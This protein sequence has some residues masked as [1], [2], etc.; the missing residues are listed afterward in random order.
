MYQ[1]A[2]ALNGGRTFLFHGSD[3][4]HDRNIHDTLVLRSTEQSAL[5]TTVLSLWKSTQRAC[6]SSGDAVSN[7][8]L[9]L[10][11]LL[12][13]GSVHRKCGLCGFLGVWLDQVSCVSS[14]E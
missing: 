11:S 7:G 3:L 8:T 12:N 14:P 10:P 5:H 4:Y 13:E 1:L 2:V 9:L 6:L